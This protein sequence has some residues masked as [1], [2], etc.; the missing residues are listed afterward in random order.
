MCSKTRRLLI[1]L[2]VTLVIETMCAAYTWASIK[3]EVTPMTAKEVELDIPIHRAVESFEEVI[4]QAEEPE[5]EP[6]EV[7]IDYG[8]S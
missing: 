1:F 8:M 2:I 4:A 6:V 3:P 5:P 7:A